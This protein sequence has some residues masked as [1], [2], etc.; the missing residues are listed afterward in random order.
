MTHRGRARS[1]GRQPAGCS[2]PASR[3]SPRTSTSR[4]CALAAEAEGL[5]TVGFLDQTYFLL[6]LLERP[7]ACADPTTSS[8]RL[9]LK[10]LLMPGGLGSTHKVLILGKGVGS[11]GAAGLLVQDAGDVTC[12]FDTEHTMDTKVWSDPIRPRCPWRP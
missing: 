11:A 1:I 12:G 9:A 5:T 4:A 2:S 10:T 8:E 6:G 3:T 7:P